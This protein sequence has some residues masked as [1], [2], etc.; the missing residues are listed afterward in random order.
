MAYLDTY[1]YLP[2]VTALFAVRALTWLNTMS[3]QATYEQFL[4]NPTS[5]FLANDASLSYVTTLVTFNEPAAIQKH[6]NSQTMQLKK[7]QDKVLGAI[8]APSGLS[9]EIETTIEFLTG[10][11]A[12]LPGLEENFLADRTVV[13]PLV[14]RLEEVG[15]AK[16]CLMSVPG[17]HCPIRSRRQ[18]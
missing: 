16:S 2:S 9:L 10:G 1:S 5:S 6:L 14:S 17:P 12:Y 18:N 8:E 4:A 7:K 11:G 3:L 15:R 13:F